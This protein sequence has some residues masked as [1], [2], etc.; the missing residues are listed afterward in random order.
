LQV[1]GGQ[2]FQ[3]QRR[4]EVEHG[5]PVVFGWST[6]PGARVRYRLSQHHIWRP[7]DR[8]S[9][10]ALEPGNH[11]VLLA[12]FDQDLQ[13]S[14]PVPLQLRVLYPPQFDKRFLVPAAALGSLAILLLL[15]ARARRGGAKP[16]A[17]RRAA[18]SAVLIV[19]LFLQLLVALFPHGRSWPFVG[20]SMY[21]EVYQPGGHTFHTRAFAVRKDGSQVELGS[22]SAGFSLFE[23]KRALVPLVFGP[24]HG[25]QQFLTRLQQSNPGQQFVGFVIRTDKRCLTSRGPVA[26][27]PLVMR[28]HPEHLLDDDR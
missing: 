6:Q 21:T 10:P 4:F 14:E 24:D 5:M 13:R 19:V 11:T 16:G 7:L 3:P 20:F 1:V 25:R 2:P 28:V 9:L 18:I 22:F 8:G 17:Y 27:A 12:A 26:V 15:L 23:W